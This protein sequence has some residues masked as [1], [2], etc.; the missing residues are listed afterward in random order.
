MENAT[1]IVTTAVAEVPA[2]NELDQ[3][4]SELANAG[5]LTRP[6]CGPCFRACGGQGFGTLGIPNRPDLDDAGGLYAFCQGCDRLVHIDSLGEP[7]DRV[8][9][10]AIIEERRQREP[11]GLNSIDGHSLFGS[12]SRA[13]TQLPSL[14]QGV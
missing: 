13:L 11:S 8:R 9:Y 1:P 3:R 4:F 5:R 10:A 12:S 6:L 2:A 14:K 7:F